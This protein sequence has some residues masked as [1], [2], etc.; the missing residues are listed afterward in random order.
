M[1]GYFRRGNFIVKSAF[2]F[3]MIFRPFTGCVLWSPL[4]S[5]Y[6]E[7]SNVGGLGS[8]LRL[9]QVW[10]FLAWNFQFFIFWK[11]DALEKYLHLYGYNDDNASNGVFQAVFKTQAQLLYEQNQE[12]L[13]SIYWG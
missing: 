1:Q 13:V 12:K 10:K 4:P 6:H 5:S 11:D 2:R 3:N 9:N 7:Y 8:I